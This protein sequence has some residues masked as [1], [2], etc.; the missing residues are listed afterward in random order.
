MS[1]LSSFRSNDRPAH[2]GVR[3]VTVAPD[4]AGQRL[5][6]F[7][8]RELKGLPRSRVY[9]LVRK[10]EVR[11]NL[12]RVKARYRLR[13]GDQ[14]RIPPVR[15]GMAAATSP[16]ETLDTG[17]VLFEDTHLLVLDK[18]SGVSVHGGTGIRAGVIEALRARRPELPFLELVHRLDRGTSGCLI[19]AKSG[20]ALRALHASLRRESDHD[21][22]KHYT[23]LVRG[24]AG[25]RPVHVGIALNRNAE[26]GGERL[27][28]VSEDGDDAESLFTPDIRGVELSRVNIE[29][30]TGRTHQA[31]VHAA[32]IGHPIAG[33]DKYGD[34]EFNRRMQRVGLKRLALHAREVKFR[35]PVTGEPCRVE[36]P[37]PTVFETAMQVNTQ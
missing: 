21:I 23:A 18:P 33:D 9:R 28:Q 16:P 36:A 3:H 11:V 6:N 8:M 17:V 2:S 30:I 4:Q 19:L 7:L 12:G 10:G 26:R 24:D 14:V 31:R 34:R 29:L 27:V 15:T 13:D 5:D 20:V 1:N 22:S 32:H 35:H 25:D 37:L